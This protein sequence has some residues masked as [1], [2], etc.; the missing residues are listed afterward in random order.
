MMGE[1]NT[2]RDRVLKEALECRVELIAYARSLLGNF[3]R[4]RHRTCS[5]KSGPVEELA[6]D[7]ANV[8]MHAILFTQLVDVPRY[9]HAKLQPRPCVQD[10]C[11]QLRCHHG[12]RR[13]LCMVTNLDKIGWIQPLQRCG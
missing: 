4:R 13:Q 7:V 6:H 1:S 10:S 11:N 3:S 2:K 8:R 12:T 5:Q 9:L